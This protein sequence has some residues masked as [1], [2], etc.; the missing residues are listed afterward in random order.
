MAWLSR[1]RVVGA[2]I[3]VLAGC[4][5]PT[6]PTPPATPIPP[7]DLTRIQVLSG[8][9]ARESGRPSLHTGV[10]YAGELGEPILAAADG[11]VVQRL[12]AEACG[13]GLI[14]EHAAW[15]RF[16]LYCHLREWKVGLNQRVTRGEVVGLMGHTGNARGRP[17]VHLEL[18]DGPPQRA[19]AENGALPKGAIDPHTVLLGC[20]DPAG[21]YPTERFV[22]TFPVR[23]RSTK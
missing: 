3:V 14:I 13:R 15:R 5:T 10:D 16:T 20:F 2:A 18:W 4:A 7:P 22:L 21:A 1:R 17:H 19:A 8:F 6:K 11:V 12:R 23:C 9:G